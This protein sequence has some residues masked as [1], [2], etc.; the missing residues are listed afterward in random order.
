MNER[1]KEIKSEYVY[2]YDLIKFLSFVQTL[3]PLFLRGFLV[4]LCMMVGLKQSK[5]KFKPRIKI[6]TNI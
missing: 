6:E 2:I 3:F 4:L 1:S 5:M